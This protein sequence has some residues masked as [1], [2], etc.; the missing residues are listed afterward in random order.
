MLAKF[1]RSRFLPYALLFLWVCL[2]FWPVLLHPDWPLMPPRSNFSDLLISHWPDAEFLRRS[3]FQYHQFPLWNPSIL[4]GAPFAADPLAGV[5]YPP[6]WLTVMLPLP[7]AFNALLIAHVT[8][9][10][11]GMYRWARAD[12]FTVWPSLLGA[13]AFAGLP[14]TLAHASAGHVSLVFALAWTPWLMMNAECGLR[15]WGSHSSLILAMIFLADPRWSVYAGAMFVIVWLVRDR[16]WLSLRQLLFCLVLFLMLAAVLWLPMLE[17]VAHSARTG[18]TVEEAGDLALQPVDLLGAVLPNLGGNHEVMTYVGIAPFILASI[19]VFKSRDRVGKITLAVIM[20]FSIWWTLGP[21][22]GLFALLSRLPGLSLLRIPSRAWF[23]VGLGVC[24]L[25]VR[26]LAEVEAGLRLAGRRWNLLTVA[27]SAIAILLGVGG[28]LVVGRPVVNLLGLALIVP[29]V[30][31]GLRLK[32]ALPILLAIMLAELFWVDASVIASRPVSPNPVAEW[33]GRERGSYWRVYSPSYSLPQ[34]DAAQYALEQ[35]DGVNPLQLAETV[36][37]MEVATGVKRNG[38]SVTVPP[39]EGE[40]ATANADAIP[41]AAL[42][43]QLNVRFVVSEFDV[44]GDGFVLRD[45]IGSTRIYE[46]VLDTGRVQGGRIVSWSPNRIVVVAD[47]PGR[48]VLSEVWYP[49]WSAWVDGVAK[50]VQ[51]AGLFRAVAL[52]PGQRQIV[53]EYRPRTVYGGIA[54]SLLGLLVVAYFLLRQRLSVLH[55]SSRRIARSAGLRRQSP[56]LNPAGAF[57][58]LLI[59]KDFRS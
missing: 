11:W 37:F 50:E 9:A 15:N 13:L 30:L 2:L 39:F 25:A 14:K 33:L 58:D 6:N 36:K 27:L 52:E 40:V 23:L 7:F 8:W 10:G 17:F 24:W 31:F 26:G 5:W 16:S 32:R 53:F 21:N 1:S 57:R 59:I 51:K 42:L 45:Q 55:E 18:L 44:R 20:L 34:L 41:N 48:V 35:A 46:N 47:G 43:S 3:L 49:G 29:S 28:S 4:G 19:G 38:Y 56:P 22:A 12:G 54:L